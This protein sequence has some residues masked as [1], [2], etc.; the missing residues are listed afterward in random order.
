[1]SICSKRRSK[2]RR[3]APKGALNRA[4]LLQKAL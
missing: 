1:V 4:E 3:A 2:P